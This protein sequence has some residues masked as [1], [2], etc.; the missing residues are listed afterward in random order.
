M[1]VSRS[2]RAAQALFRRLAV[3]P[4]AGIRTAAPSAWT[5]VRSP[6]PSLFFLLLLL[7]FFHRS[8][9]SWL[10]GAREE[11]KKSCAVGV[12]EL[13]AIAV[14]P[15]ALACSRRVDDRMIGCSMATPGEL[16]EPARVI[17]PPGTRRRASHG[18]EPSSDFGSSAG[19]R[20]LAHKIPLQTPKHDSL[21][22]RRRVID[23]DHEL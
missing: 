22:P 14:R 12:T 15:T 8:L 9:Q 3:T 11:K 7:L 19:V 23:D 18:R 6:S 17:D 4:G 10:L 16:D 5:Q 13:V 21:T 1:S 20:I 2:S